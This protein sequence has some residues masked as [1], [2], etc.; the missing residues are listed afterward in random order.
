MCLVR[1]SIRC[2]SRSIYQA[3]S[4]SQYLSQ[5]S[6]QVRCN[7]ECPTYI[8]V[9]GKNNQLQY[10]IIYYISEHQFSLVINASHTIPITR[11]NRGPKLLKLIGWRHCPCFRWVPYIPGTTARLLALNQALPQDSHEHV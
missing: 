10:I 2:R 9:S 7:I 1:Y 8:H 3:G 4:V 11:V 6:N 5:M